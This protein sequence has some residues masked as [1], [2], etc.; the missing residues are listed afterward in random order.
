ME[1]FGKYLEVTP[2]KRLV[3][4]NEEGSGDGA[5]S[6]VTFEEQGGKTLVRM[7]DVYPSK[8]A[9]D[10]GIGSTSGAGESFDQLE[11]LLGTLGANAGRLTDGPAAEAA[12]RRGALTGFRRRRRSRPGQ[13]RWDHGGHGEARRTAFDVVGLAGSVRHRLLS[14]RNSR[15]PAKPFTAPCRAAALAAGQRAPSI[16]QP[17][18]RPGRPP[19]CCSTLIAWCDRRLKPPLGVAP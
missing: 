5:V 12:A 3:W 9:L 13:D 16:P 19:L 15:R 6:T 14:A 7:S 18:G 4:T 11:A 10:E 1:F 8:E 17:S 2:N